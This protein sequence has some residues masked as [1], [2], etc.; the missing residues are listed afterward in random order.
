[1]KE[2]RKY[3]VKGNWIFNLESMHDKIWCMIYDIQEGKCDHVTILG[4]DMGI[5]ELY[6]FMNECDDLAWKAQGK[7]T[8]KEYGRI[9]AIS[10]ARNM[11]RYA[12]CLA[13]GASE[14]EAGNAFFD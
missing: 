6:D 4:K 13:N 2:E 9:K 14:E 1:M 10:D 12:T 5:S 3:Y 7:V 8:S 11:I